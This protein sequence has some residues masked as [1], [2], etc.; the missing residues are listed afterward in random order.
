MRPKAIALL[1][2]E[3]GLDKKSE[4]PVILDLSKVSN[5]AE[6][7][8]I[9]HGNSAPHV[10]AIAEHLLLTMK[11]KKVPLFHQEGL[12]EGLWI[13][14]DYGPVIVHVFYKDTREYYALERLWGDAP[15]L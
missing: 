13:L 1:A 3:I 14:L 8:V 11:E 2:R 5:V 6:Y 15:R 9:L 7:F 12:A 10:K 4:D